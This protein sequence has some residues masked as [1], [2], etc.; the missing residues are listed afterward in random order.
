MEHLPVDSVIVT[1]EGTYGLQ[2]AV[3]NVM[4][5][6]CVIAVELSFIY[7]EMIEL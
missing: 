5:L 7:Q 2:L 3:K 4:E 1:K 6:A